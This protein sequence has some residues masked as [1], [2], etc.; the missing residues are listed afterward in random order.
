MFIIVRDCSNPQAAFKYIRP[1]W[2]P[3]LIIENELKVEGITSVIM[4][5]CLS[6]IS[7]TGTHCIIF[8]TLNIS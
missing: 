1:L 4:F 2:L 7:Y 6:R 8:P 3:L 5:Y